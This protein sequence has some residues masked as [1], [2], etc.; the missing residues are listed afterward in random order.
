MMDVRQTQLAVRVPFGA[1]PEVRWEALVV[2]PPTHPAAAL[3]LAPEAAADLRRCAASGVRVVWDGRST[4]SWVAQGRGRVGALER[5][6]QQVR[7][8]AEVGAA[9]VL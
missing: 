9:V 4:G 8:A 3:V 5:A 6:R 7:H 2:A 1:V